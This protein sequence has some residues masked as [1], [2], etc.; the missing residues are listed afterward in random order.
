MFLSVVVVLRTYQ[1][2]DI[3]SSVERAFG[4]CSS[5]TSVTFGNPHTVYAENA[6]ENTGF[7]PP[8]PDEPEIDSE[9][10]TVTNITMYAIENTN[11]RNAPMVDNSTLTGNIAQKGEALNVVGIRTEDGWAKIKVD[12]EILYIR[13]PQLTFEATE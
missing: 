7:V 4:S 3:T 8:V 9:G 10:F 11:I 12:G 1:V 13:Y 5:L 6:F 2:Q